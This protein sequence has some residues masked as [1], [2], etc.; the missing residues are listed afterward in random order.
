MSKLEELKEAVGKFCA[1]EYC[2][3]PKGFKGDAFMLYAVD[4]GGYDITDDVI[5]ALY[6]DNLTIT[7][8]TERAMPGYK[9]KTS[10]TF[11]LQV[12]EE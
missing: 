11:R 7:V 8:I 1:A 12:I 4:G 5:F 3:D 6:G 2:D 9:P 10:K